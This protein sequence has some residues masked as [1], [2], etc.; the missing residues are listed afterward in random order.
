MPDKSL[1]LLPMPEC[2]GVISAHCNLHLL[3]SRDPQASASQVAGITG[4]CHHVQ[5]IFVFFLVETGSHHIGQADLQQ[6]TSV[7][8]THFSI[9]HPDNNK[10][11]C[12]SV[13]DSKEGI[14]EDVPTWTGRGHRKRRGPEAGP[15]RHRQA[16]EWTEEQ[17]RD[18]QDGSQFRKEL[19]RV[20]LPQKFHLATEIALALGLEEGG[21][22][23]LTAVTFSQHVLPVLS[24]VER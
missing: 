9:V 4:A 21:D 24:R 11:L 23:L 15:E 8:C 12:L 17:H 1:A 7:Q 13:A 3:G 22:E 14:R 20:F 19:P 6:L 16:E 2:S 5:L 18:L 10:Y